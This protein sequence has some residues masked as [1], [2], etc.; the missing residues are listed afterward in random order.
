LATPTTIASKYSQESRIASQRRPNHA[1]SLLS[2]S[3]RATQAFDTS[4]TSRSSLHDESQGVHRCS[5]ERGFGINGIAIVDPRSEASPT[6]PTVARIIQ[7]PQPNARPGSYSGPDALSGPTSAPLPGAFANIDSASVVGPSPGSM[8][9]HHPQQEASPLSSIWS[10]T[11]TIPAK[12]IRNTQR[13]KRA[14][15]KCSSSL[16]NSSATCKG[17]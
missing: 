12:T 13:N 3:P 11:F 4:P 16:R 5:N 2:N 8:S 17:N 6:P 15:S 10:S 14:W 9:S 1:S 7:F